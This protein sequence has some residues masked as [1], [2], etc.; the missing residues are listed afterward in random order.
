MNQHKLNNIHT[1]ES[2][3]VLLIIVMLLATVLTIVMTAALST[4]TQTQTTKDQEEAIKVRAAAESALDIALGEPISTQQKKF[5]EFESLRNLLTGI[6][7]EESYIQVS[8]STGNSFVSPLIEKDSQYT[9]YMTNYVDGEFTG[10]PYPPTGSIKVLYG[11]TKEEDCSETA[12]EFTI[13]SGTSG[14]Y[15]YIRYIADYGNKLHNPTNPNNGNIGEPLTISR[16][17]N[18]DKAAN[19]VQFYCQAIFPTPLPTNAKM[20]FA[21]PLY[22]DTRLGFES[23]GASLPSQGKTVRAVAKSNTGVTKIVE[24]FQSF[25]QLPSSLFVTS[26]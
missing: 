23:T 15:N 25:P 2:G 21:R 13:L 11:N 8:G 24:L 6:N 12:I 3:Q 7:L 20:I 26:F 1:S 22:S 5:S 16:P 4:T 18:G 19:A 17:V 9:F 14:G 10:N